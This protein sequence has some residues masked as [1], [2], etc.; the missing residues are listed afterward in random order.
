MPICPSCGAA[1]AGPAATCANCGR[2]LAAP[3]IGDVVEDTAPVGAGSPWG[4][5]KVHHTREAPLL[6]RGWLTAGRVLVAPT[7]LLVLSAVIG[8]ASQDG[9]SSRTAMPFGAGDG[10]QSWLS[11]V[12]TAFG[13]PLRIVMSAVKRRGDGSATSL[14]T[15]VHLVLY[16]VALGWLLALWSGLHLGVRARRRAG[17]AE[18]AGAAVGV[19]ALRT[20]A[21]SAVVALLLGW[22]AGQDSDGGD[23]YAAMST[24]VGPSLLPLA[25]SAG[26]AAV[27][28]VLA[29]DGAAALRAEAARRG[30]LG[31]L[32]VA[33]QHAFRVVLA[34]LVLLTAVGLVM[35]LSYGDSLWNTGTLAMVT[36][37]GVM[38]HGLG[39]GATLLVGGFEDSRLSV[40]LFDLGDHGDGWWFALLPA[41]VAALA[42]GWSA[43][44]GRLVQRDRAVL[45]GV[46]A[47]LNALLLL[48]T[49]VWST[50]GGSNSGSGGVG[51]VGGLTFRTEDVLGWSVL[52]V[53]V[54]SAVW[55]VFGA[56]AVPGLLDGLRGTPVPLAPPRPV[57]PP[58]PAVPPVPGALP[59]LPGQ[60]VGERLDTVAH[61]SVELVVDE[62]AAPAVARDGDAD[63]H[64]AFRRPGTD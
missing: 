35:Q 52:S 47:L 38:V 22:L 58:M 5:G 39:S 51:G 24:E 61:G 12:L 10:F 43:H 62:P 26:L 14:E 30:W 50:I 15:S 32:L 34:L 37:Y 6:S 9:A 8:T 13:A 19:Q 57:A 45:A 60:A 23:G 20:G 3:A 54:S 17:A 7:A 49:S 46:Y 1:S 4:T 28:L 29:V 42:L 31:S 36:N 53:L 55:G 48:G 16:L 11:L 25:L 63:P 27:V 2:P 40:S 41:L 21:V 44:R 64:A 18:P 33:W 56:L 59:S